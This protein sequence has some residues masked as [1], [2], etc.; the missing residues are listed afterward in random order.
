MHVR[1]AE[2]MPTI[3]GVK[4]VRPFSIGVNVR[5]VMKVARRKVRS[6]SVEVEFIILEPKMVILRILQ[7]ITPL[8]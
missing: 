3:K 5:S 6:H 2:N 8:A 7:P 4:S 1:L